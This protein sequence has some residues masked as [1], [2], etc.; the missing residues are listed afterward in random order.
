MLREEVAAEPVAAGATLQKFIQETDEG[1]LK[2]YAL[3]VDL[4][5]PYVKVDVLVGAD[6]QT[7]G[8]ASPVQEK[9]RRS[10]AVAALNGDF[11][12]LKGGRHPL[13]LTVKEGE[14]L[15][16][17]LLGDDFYAFA[18]TRDLVPLIELFRFEGF[19]RAVPPAG[20]GATQNGGAPNAA[21]GSSGAPGG[22]GAAPS[23]AAFPLA[24]I[25]KPRYS[26]SVGGGV[27]VS[28]RGRLHLYNSRWGALSPGAQ[29][30]LPGWVEVVVEDGI[31][32]EVREDQPPVVIPARG[33]VLVGH[34]AAADFLRAACV[35]G[36]RVSVEYR[37][38]PR[39]EEIQTAVGGK[40]LLVERGEPVAAFSKE[41][42]GKFARSAVGFSRDGRRLYL[43][44]VEGGKESR[45]MYQRELAEFLANRLGLWRALNLDGGGST[46]LAVRPLGEELPVLMNNPA[47]GTPR[48]VPNVL[49]I[50]STAPRGRLAGLVI[51]GPREVLAGLDCSF[52]VRGYDEYYNPYPVE[53]GEVVW[54]LREGSGS[55]EG[56]RFHAEGSGVAVLEAAF[57]GVRQEHRV[58]VI[59]PADLEGLEVTPGMVKL[60]PGE[61]VPLQAQ[62]R[63]KD[64]RVWP[65]PAGRVRWEMEG[66]IGS[67]RNGKFSAGSADAAGKIR[68]SFLGFTVEIPVTVGIPLPP[69]V[70]DHWAR[71]PVR[72]LIARDVVRGYPDGTFRPERAVTRA[73]FVTI[74]ARALGWSVSNEASL[75]FKD[76]I[77][78]WALPYLK[79]AWSRGVIGGY[80]DG[81]FRPDRAISR[82]E[83]AV[84]ITR[85]LKLPEACGQVA[86]KDAHQIPPWAQEAVQRAAAAGIMQGSG[87]YCRPAAFATRAEVA[88]LVYQSLLYFSRR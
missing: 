81:T 80:P 68:G 45:G 71:L 27:E 61:E 51:R 64:G 62:V 1:P 16:S 43:V 84:L 85:A 4:T 60:N 34:G 54:T 72:E 66:P 11:F 52:E 82:A 79:A 42:E 17:P 15:T 87:G 5:N 67:V 83:L 28:H 39:G 57:R 18:L 53:A 44:A 8:A 77:P 56:N 33:F 20:A 14:V 25:N 74:L 75:P 23:H 36:A 2:I 40:N 76:E 46:S 24:G 6:N 12:H 58:R 29:S 21:A 69:D 55:F 86:F 41:L 32:R 13:G 73:E 50:F 35:P 19:V 37:V 26:V 59:G 10:G 30:D 48:P 70:A 9:A 38:A 88:A 65:L 63:G 3:S 47:Q 7:F 49:G 31:V 78:G 22:A